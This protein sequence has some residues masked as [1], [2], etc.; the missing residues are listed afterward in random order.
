MDSIV[1]FRLELNGLRKMNYKSIH[2]GIKPMCFVSASEFLA[3]YMKKLLLLFGF[4]AALITFEGHAWGQTT[5]AALKPIIDGTG[6][7]GKALF[8]RLNTDPDG[9]QKRNIKPFVI[10]YCGWRTKTIAQYPMT[11]FDGLQIGLCRT[12]LQ[13]F[14]GQLTPTLTSLE[15][16]TS[17]VSE[18]IDASKDEAKAIHDF[19]VL[20]Y[21]MQ[22][23]GLLDAKSK[24]DPVAKWKFNVGGNLGEIAAHLTIWWRIWTNPQYEAQIGKLLA[25]LGDDIKNAPKGA[26]P[27]FLAALRKLNTYGTKAKFTREERANI[28]KLLTDALTASLSLAKMPNVSD[29]TPAETTSTPVLG[30]LPATRKTAAQYLQDGKALAAKGEFQKAIAEYDLGTKAEPGNGIL[31]FNRALAREKLGQ[32]DEAIRDYDAVLL[33]RASLREAY[34]NRGTLFLNKKDYQAAIGDFDAAVALDPKYGAALYNRGL[35]HYGA[36]DLFAAQAD[37]NNLIKLQPKN[38]NAYIM[39]SYVYCSQGLR[40][41]RDQ[42]PATR[43]QLGGQVEMA[44]N[45]RGLQKSRYSFTL[46]QNKSAEIDVAPMQRLALDGIL[47]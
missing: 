41:V 16:Q 42:G 27:T 36:Q 12:I 44:V 2:S 3:K 8:E 43:V 25:G 29:S 33:L 28:N 26:D 15:S 6:A 7:Y 22:Y 46:T 37:F 23:L 24:P 35:A 40:N 19:V 21:G 38:P 13:S 17:S 11:K 1:L 9:T 18:P 5:P 10:G 34:F 30:S 39:R 31:Y 47:R 32:V 20:K 4:S 14:D 45:S